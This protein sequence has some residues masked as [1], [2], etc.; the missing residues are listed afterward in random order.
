MQL[1]DLIGRK[2]PGGGIAVHGIQKTV[3]IQPIKA[4]QHGGMKGITQQC[5]APALAV[6]RARKFGPVALVERLHA[7]I[8]RTRLRAGL[9]PRHHKGRHIFHNI[10]LYVAVFR[11]FWGH[12][13]R[14]RL[15]C[16]P[17]GNGTV[18]G[19]GH[20]ALY[21]L[22]C[23]RAGRS[24]RADHRNG[25]RRRRITQHIAHASQQ[26]AAGGVVDDICGLFLP[27][28]TGGFVAREPVGCA[29]YQN[30]RQHCQ[31][32]GLGRARAGGTGLRHVHDIRHAQWFSF[33]L[34]KISY[35]GDSLCP[36]SAR[37]PNRLKK[38]HARPL[39]TFIAR[40][41]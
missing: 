17:R 22:P 8:Q 9:E 21:G 19:R 15:A 5:V 3:C 11:N 35:N 36:R 33:Q 16:L 1:A 6:C 12:L 10:K 24:G 32:H 37:M 14:I 40:K 7:Y 39:F 25:R 26:C 30:H 20:A 29:A 18:H 4:A 2:A 41:C 28:V 13:P 23:Q 27:L 38:R 31:H 34:H